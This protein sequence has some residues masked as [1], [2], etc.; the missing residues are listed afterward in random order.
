MMLTE[1][2]Q[3]FF[4]ILGIMRF[5]DI[6]P[7]GLVFIC[8]FLGSIMNSFAGGGTF[9][10]F[11]ALIAVGLP[12]II[13][14]ATCKIAFI[15]GNMASAFA[16]R[17]FFSEARPIIVKMLLVGLIGG[18]IGASLTLALGNEGFQKFVPWLILTATFLAWL[19]PTIN[20]LLQ[21]DVKYIK[22]K[23]VAFFRWG[24]QGVTAL[25]GGFFGAGIGILLIASLGLQGLKNI[26]VI[27]AIK[28]V[29]S[30]VINLAAIVIYSVA[31]T[32]D[33]HFA[34]IQIIGAIA[35]GYYGGV[36]GKSLNPAFIRF[37]IIMIGFILSGVYFYKY[38]YI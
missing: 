25:Y 27:N 2:I 7:I 17:Q 1:H 30:V 28:N 3:D 8:G 23:K 14:N 13:A 26:N 16:Y 4:A 12:P 11:P 38:G 35:G 29:M 20:K 18:I 9:I 6:L 37:L 31:D 5:E 24:L 34:I 10:A 19:T 36:F 15:P 21:S 32:I 22:S 33:W